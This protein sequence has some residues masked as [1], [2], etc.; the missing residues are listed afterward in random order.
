MN[1]EPK[2]YGP[3]N[4]HPLSLLRTELVWEGKYDEYGRRRLVSLPTFPL[5]MQRIETIDE[6]RDR[7]KAQGTLFEP[8]TAHRD[9]FRNRLIWGD[10]KLAI[11]SLLPEFRG[12]VKLIYIDPPFDVGMNFGLDVFLGDQEEG[13]FKEQ[14]ALEEVAYSDM[15]GNG[16]DSYLHMMYERLTLLKELLSEDGSIFVHCDWHVGHLLR[17]LL[18]ETFGQDCFLNEIVWYYYNKLHDSRKKI[19][20]RAHDVIFRYAKT[21]GLQTHHPLKEIRDKPVTKLKYRKVNGQIQ[22]IIGDDGKAVT[23]VSDDRTIDDVWRIRCLQPA[24]KNENLLFATQKPENLLERIIEVASDP[25]DIVAD[26][27]IG[28][29]TTLAVAEKL[30]RRWIGADLGRYSIH[31]T[32][33]RLIG[34]QRE[35]N[36]QAKP[37]RSFDVYNLGRYERQWWQ[38]ERLKGA[39]EEHR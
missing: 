7:S 24:N 36:E 5:A 38:M 31:T 1:N 8:A 33:K 23:Y 2:A 10:N 4:P 28:S 18:T 20:P 6:P 13:L 16:V 25:D 14:S 37:Y 34:V 39:D 30:G 26:F 19:L 21:R 22:N 32:R 3:N 35:L 11:A 15:W 12:K 9:D 27:F 29:G 17:Q